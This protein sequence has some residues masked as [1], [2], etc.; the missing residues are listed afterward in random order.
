MPLRLYLLSQ[1][2]EN[3]GSWHTICG[4]A[5]LMSIYG[6]FADFCPVTMKTPATD[7]TVKPA[8]DDGVV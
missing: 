5:L 3:L 1:F 8:Q 2:I 6:K 4:I 7:P